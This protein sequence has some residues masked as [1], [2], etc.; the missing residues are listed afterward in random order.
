MPGR[1]F[2]ISKNTAEDK[3]TLVIRDKEYEVIKEVESPKYGKG[4]LLKKGKYKFYKYEGDSRLLF[5][6][7]IS[8]KTAPGQKHGMLTIIEEAERDKSN[9]VS[10]VWCQCDCGNVIKVWVTS[11]L[12]GK[13]TDCGCYRSKIPAHKHFMTNSKLYRSWHRHKQWCSNPKIRE[14]KNHG[15]KGIKM[16]DE[17]LGENGF[18]NYMEWALKEGYDETMTITRFNQ[19]KDFCPENCRIMPAPE[20][21][22]NFK[23]KVFNEAVDKW[24]YDNCKKYS[25]I[26]MAEI[27][28]IDEAL[29]L[30]YLSFKNYY[31][32]KVPWKE[33][34]ID[35][36]KKWYGKIP[37]RSLLPLI[38]KTEQGISTK[39][40]ALG[41]NEAAKCYKFNLTL[42]Q[43][44]EIYRR[45]NAGDQLGIVAREVKASVGD[46]AEFMKVAEKPFY[47]F[48]R[49]E[50]KDK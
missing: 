12:A 19:E 44:K 22:Y 48:L 20:N 11:L 43:A 46:A 14:Y 29:M 2:E 17:W 34:Q 28:G 15:G 7:E 26:E 42:E 27:T 13:R 31:Q 35:L 5:A 45:V 16:C 36:L 6:G 3:K 8:K 50:K 18:M 39:A 47:D 41:L 37:M 1:L 10:K 4:L 21:R 25:Y 33:W 30:R 40:E 38:G 49:K 9:C 23:K 24:I 32:R